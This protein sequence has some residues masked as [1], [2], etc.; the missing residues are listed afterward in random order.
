MP[1][2]YLA[3]TVSILVYGLDDQCHSHMD[4]VAYVWGHWSVLGKGVGLV[5]GGWCL[6]VAGSFAFCFLLCM[7]FQK[8][9]DVTRME[10]GLMP[11]VEMEY[12]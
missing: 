8:R 3:F 1:G 10:M 11:T 4:P 9:M 7:E 2:T 5:F 12:W 6:F